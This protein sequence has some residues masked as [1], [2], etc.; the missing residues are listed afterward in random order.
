MERVVLVSAGNLL[1][2]GA[3][4]GR[5]LLLPEPRPLDRRLEQVF[6]PGEP[7]RTTGYRGGTGKS[8]EIQREEKRRRCRPVADGVTLIIRLFWPTREA[9]PHHGCF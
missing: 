4:M 8:P 5:M 6:T 7:V 1:S 3:G 2:V 9:R